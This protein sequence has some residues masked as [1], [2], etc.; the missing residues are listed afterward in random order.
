MK[1]FYRIGTLWLL[2]AC[3]EAQVPVPT[4]T[5]AITAAPPS[6]ATGE[7]FVL[8]AGTNTAFLHNPVLVVE[9]FDLDNSMNWP[10]LYAL[11]NKENLVEEILSFGRDLI[12]LNFSD[13]T[14]N[15]HSN[16]ALNAEAINYIQARRADPLDKFTAIGA[17]LGGLTL[18]MALADMPDHDV[19]A[20]ISFDSPHEGANIPLGVQEYLEFFGSY[21]Q[22]AAD[23]LDALDRPAAR[24]MLIAHHDHSDGQAGGS[25]PERADYAAALN[26]IGYPAE[27]KGIAISNGSGLGT[28]QPFAAGEKVINWTDSGGI[29]DPD[30]ES[31]VYALPQ[32]SGVVFAAEVRLIIPIDSTTVNTYHP[33]PLDNAPGG[34]RGTFLQL[35]TNI[36]PDQI[37]GD[38]FCN[39]TNHCFIPTVSALG[40]PLQHIESNLAVHA[41]LLD[42]SPFDEIHYAVTNEPHV[43]IN[44]R[45]KRWIMRAIL[46]DHDSDNDGLDDYQ[47]FLLGTDYLSSD[48]TL[49]IELALTADA[50]AFTVSWHALP[51]A[52]YQVWYTPELGTEWTL[53]DTLAPAPDDAVTNTY[54][55]P[56]TN[57]TG[58]IYVSGY[59]VDPVID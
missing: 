39:Y 10:E 27:C 50:G 5:I 42:L 53:I 57:R 52:G 20:W 40:I 31:A 59:P 21:N 58:F 9:G 30:I 24:Q 37:S 26:A 12:V 43:E 19:D 28:K 38:D 45:N 35:Y 16:A 56:E 32:T 33:L 7:L 18:R 23:L 49:P 15:I 47:E 36:P 54:L 3:A 6:S 1:T 41:T 22:A 29:F 51:N 8:K 14:L 2:A 44:P 13:S 55:Y 4:E 25:L 48:E 11:L 34:T 17:S 46:E